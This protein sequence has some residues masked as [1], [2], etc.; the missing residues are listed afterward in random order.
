M[1]DLFTAGH[2]VAV[3]QALSEANKAKFCAWP[4]RQ[5]AAI[6]FCLTAQ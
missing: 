4:A 3:Y 2:I 6:A 1:V 5:M